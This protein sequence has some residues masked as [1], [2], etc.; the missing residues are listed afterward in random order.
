MGS[1]FVRIR[2]T[3]PISPQWGDLRSLRRK[4]GAMLVSGVLWNARG[5]ENATWPAKLKDYG[6]S[7]GNHGDGQDVTKVDE[8]LCNTRRKPRQPLLLEQ[9]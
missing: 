3:I 5:R 6:M 8:E 9:L 1:F 4:S 7:D 2:P